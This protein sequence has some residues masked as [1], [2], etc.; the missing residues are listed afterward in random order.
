VYETIRKAGDVIQSAS[1]V[2]AIPM[3]AESEKELQR[4]TVPLAEADNLIT[5][6]VL[7]RFMDQLKRKDD[8]KVIFYLIKFYLYADRVD[9]DQRDKLDFLFTRIGEDFF[10]SRG[11]YWSK[12]P[13]ELRKQIESLVSVRPVEFTDSREI[14]RLVNAMRTLKSEIQQIESFEHLT[15]SRLLDDSRA[16][17]HRMGNYF[18][19]P[20]VLIAIVDCNVTARNRFLRYYTEEEQRLIEDA[21]RLIDNEEAIARGF[22]SSNP[23][24]MQEIANF[25]QLKQEFEEARANFNVKHNLIAQLKASMNAILAHLDRVV[26]PP[27]DQ[28]SEEQLLDEHRRASV[29]RIFGDDPL[30][31]DHLV[32]IYGILDSLDPHL[33]EEQIAAAPELGDIRLEPWEV[34]AYLKLYH[35]AEMEATDDEE[36]LLLYLRSAALRIKISE[37]ATFL[38][39]FPPHRPIQGTLLSKVKESLDRANTYDQNFVS[40]LHDE[41]HYSS[42]RNLHRLYRSRFRLLRVFSGLWLIYDGFTG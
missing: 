10:E 16:L 9:G 19:H 30:L 42:S 7:R 4:I 3:M 18:F 23:E 8:K 17:K 33:G 32:R 40:L 28:I 15:A 5:P 37:E 2:T 31:N 22:G 21:Q 27:A 6:P 13:G 12:D 20:D 11:E 1:A 29:R 41:I 25:R 24:L 39:A 26:P 14:V 38:A 35:S 34:A 36:L